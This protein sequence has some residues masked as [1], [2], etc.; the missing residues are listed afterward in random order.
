MQI[1]RRRFLETAAAGTAGLLVA[2]SQLKGETLAANLDPTALVPLGKRLKV[3]RI[4]MGTGV[5]AMN[6][7]SKQ[8]R[9]G[10]EK[11]EKIISK[12]YDE[13]IRYFDTA[14]VYGSHQIVAKALKGKPRDSYTLVSKVWLLPGGLPE[15]EREDAD[16]AVKRFLKECETDYIDLLQIHC[17]TNGKWPEQMRKQMDLLEGLRE[18]GLIRSHGVSCHS[19]PALEAA[20]NE[21]WV[22]V[23][24]ARIN[25]DGVYMDG[26]PEKVVPVLKKIHESGKGV[27]GMKIIG[28]G[29][30]KNDPA[31]REASFRYVFNLG[32][33]DVITVG[34][35]ELEEIQNTKELTK[36]AL[37]SKA[38]KVNV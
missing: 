22:E 21:P 32:T 18:K 23:V 12:A 2:G 26:S 31:K 29:Q 9:N 35:E 25:P 36:L 24:H 11:F 15:E 20:A 17:L 19:L 4:G 13:G 1:H 27:I 37:E 10:I 33:V 34:F 28:Q 38:T 16:V 30:Y 8:I 14:D 7:T 3:S 5:S 6:R